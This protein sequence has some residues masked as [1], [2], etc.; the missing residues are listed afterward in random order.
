MITFLTMLFLVGMLAGAV[1]T[2]LLI[3]IVFLTWVRW[4][5]RQAE[6]VQRKAMQ[7]GAVEAYA[8]R[9]AENTYPRGL[10]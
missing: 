5:V 2:L 7:V 4:S 3:A 9:V 8:Q 6:E 1:V 10:H